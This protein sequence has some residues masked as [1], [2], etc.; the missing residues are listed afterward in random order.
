[1]PG[2]GCRIRGHYFDA[3]GY[4][5][6][7]WGYGGEKK[8]LFACREFFAALRAAPHPSPLSHGDYLRVARRREG[9]RLR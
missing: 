8:K 3:M 4:W 1:M 2:W 6:D 7:V 5:R 9:V